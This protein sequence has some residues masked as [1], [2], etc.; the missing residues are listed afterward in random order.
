MDES[1]VIDAEAVQRLEE[2]GGRTLV[3]EM[4][5]IF[6]EHSPRRVEEIRR[7]LA[8]EGLELTERGAHS[9]K[10]SAGN[11][12]ART[13]QGISRRIEDCAA[14]GDPEGARALLEELE[15]AYGEARTALELLKE[16]TDG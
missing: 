16:K 13:L 9:L 10:S 7:G 12:G 3:N 5:R 6:L 4:T 15:E 8:G 14:E 11:L 2:W 1:D